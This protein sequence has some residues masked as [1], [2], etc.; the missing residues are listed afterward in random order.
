MD[1]PLIDPVLQNWIDKWTIDAPCIV[2]MLQSRSNNGPFVVQVS[3]QFCLSGSISGPDGPFIDPILQKL[4][5]K[6]TITCLGCSIVRYMFAKLDRTPDYPTHL[7]VH[8][9]IHVFESGSNSGACTVHSSIH[10]CETGSKSGPSIA[11][12]QQI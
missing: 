1:G 5:E 6:W 10:F 4:I 9:S 3:L 12:A 2:A 8:V 11:S 7:M